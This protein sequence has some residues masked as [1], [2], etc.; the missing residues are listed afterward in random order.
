MLSGTGTSAFSLDTTM[1]TFPWTIAPMADA[2]FDV[3]YRP[4]AVGSNAAVLTVNSDDASTPIRT[5]NI[6]ATAANAP[7]LSLS[8]T[9]VDFGDTHTLAN[10][11]VVITAHN[12]GGSELRVSSLAISATTA[13]AFS[14]DPAS[15][16]PIAP[17]D[18]QTFNVRY[19]PQVPSFPVVQ[20]GAVL[21]SSNDPANPGCKDRRQRPGGESDRAVDP[22][23]TAQLQQR[24]LDPNHPKHLRGRAG[25]HQHRALQ[26]RD[27]SDA[28]VEL[29]DQQRPPRNVHA[30]E[31]AGDAVRDQLRRERADRGP[32]SRD[33][34]RHRQR[35]LVDQHQRSRSTGRESDR[36]LGR[37]HGEL[38]LAAAYDRH[39]NAAGTCSYVCD[40]NFY[41]VDGDPATGCEYGCNFV[42]ASDPPDD[43][44]IDANCDGVDGIAANGIFVSTTG[45]DNFPG[46]RAQPMRTIQA[47]IGVAAANGKM[48][49]VSGGSYSMATPLQ[50][51]NGVSIY[52]AYSSADWTRAVGNV[53]TLTVGSP[54]AVR[55][56]AISSPTVI[57]HL[58]IVGGDNG[59]G[60][61]VRR[62]RDEQQRAHDPAVR[63][64]RWQ[65]LRRL[66]WRFA[67]WRGRSRR[68]RQ[69]GPRRLRKFSGLLLF[70]KL[71]STGRRG[72]GMSACGRTGGMGASPG[73][74][75]GGGQ[76]G[77]TG[78]GG[79]PGGPG[80]GCCQGNWNTPSTY[81][82]QDGANGGAGTD[83]AAGAANFT[84]SGY[85]PSNGLG[86]GQG[87]DA[88]G[89]GGGGGWPAVATPIATPTEAPA[90]GGA[91]ALRRCSRERR[92]LGLR[93]L[94]DLSV[95]L[96]LHA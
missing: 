19:N 5:I 79:T 14:V 28:G 65:R 57:D 23:A 2:T 68:Q 77:G 33:D 21:V 18:S 72:G 44:F 53:T 50:P 4:T 24:A 30:G 96:E 91:R 84:S 82:G 8:Q 73:L 61:G 46:T 76:A 7:V 48:L 89:G 75:G 20:A 83:G 11:T 43:S 54:I 71:R 27:R 22:A 12:T 66:R 31:P 85:A 15:L 34:A 40:A 45:N 64:H 70:H 52:G 80:I 36:R 10:A 92:N 32:V 35:D 42:S 88:N 86:G 17:G 81:W 51:A 29:H 58:S 94:R 6:T 62:V 90:V 9:R 93:L 25:H 49:F 26:Q 78:V 41:D 87:A 13:M 39:R 37:Q 1:L 63:D 69:S 55:A 38:P 60:S 59:A 74:G 47:A 67:G 56:D 3:V 95:E 16:P